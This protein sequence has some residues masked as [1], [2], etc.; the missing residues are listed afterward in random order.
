MISWLVDPNNAPLVG[1]L[2]L[3]LAVLAT[4]PTLIGLYFTYK[5]ARDA[6]SA[7]DTARRAVLEFRARTDRYDASGDLAEVSFTLESTRNQITRGSWREAADSY[8]T[9][10]RAAVR[11]HTS[12]PNLDESDKQALQKMTDQMARFC[13][14]VD[15]AAAGKGSYPDATKVAAAIRKHHDLITQLQRIVRT[16]P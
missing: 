16:E 15:A 4:P 10:R 12:A 11:V 5:Q 2:G 7:A 9:A 13:N 1:A 8:E 14:A 3:A 6:A